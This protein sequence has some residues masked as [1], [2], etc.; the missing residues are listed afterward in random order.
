MTEFCCRCRPIF[1]IGSLIFTFSLS[2]SWGRGFGP[3]PVHSQSG[4]GCC[5]FDEVGLM[6]RLQFR[7]FLIGRPQDF[8]RASES[9]YT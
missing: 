4:K 2:I 6:D 9:Y 8:F 3:T 7:D 5:G 1:R